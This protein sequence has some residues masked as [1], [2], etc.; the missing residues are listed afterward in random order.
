MSSAD[1][2]AALQRFIDLSTLPDT[3]RPD[4]LQLIGHGAHE[5]I[6]RHGL[7]TR[8]DEQWR[9]TSLDG[10]VQ[11][12]FVAAGQTTVP[13]TGDLAEYQIAGLDGWQLVL[14][15]GRFDAGL[16]R[17]DNLPEGLRLGGLAA[18]LHA[19]PE[20][21]RN[22]LP[23]DAAADTG[24]FAQLNLAAVRD[25]TLIEVAAGCHIDRPIE[26]LHL[27]I[28]A[29][30]A[31]FA[32]PR[33]LIDIGRGA[34]LT[35]VERYVAL[36]P[37]GYFNNIVSD[38]TLAEGARL[39]HCRI[40]HE[41]PQAFH[42]QTQFIRQAATSHYQGLQIALGGSWARTDTRVDL[43][44]G[45][46]F[47]GIDGLYLAGGGQLTDTHLDVRHLAAGCT[48]RAHFR[49]LLDGKGRAVFDGRILVAKD[50]QKTDARLHNAN[51]MLSRE[52]EVDTKP[53]LEIFADDVACS[54]GTTV[55]QIEPEQL[56]YLRS[57]GIAETDARVMICQ[58]FAAA[59]LEHC[60]LPAITDHVT[61][62]IAQRLRSAV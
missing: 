46:A 28:G 2:T 58:G 32:Q 36:G 42:L 12:P 10:L 3:D 48:S 22:H 37:S 20:R 27:S 6:R 53:Q 44:G 61:H 38:I 47:C 16:S 29:E 59:A 26:I 60:P 15:N 7:P 54:H 33:H 51:L 1:T 62:L 23:R 17:L 45:G 34:S 30:V 55:G 31:T 41:S 57:R 4:W 25:G 21:V 43:V 11:T 13:N 8:R 49:G 5:Q 9:Y 19:E 35:L 39:E 50:A 56:F 14:V 40:Q 18:A 24:I 52:A